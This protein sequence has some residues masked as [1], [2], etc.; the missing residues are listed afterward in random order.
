M[1]FYQVFMI[2]CVT[3]GTPMFLLMANVIYINMLNSCKTGLTG[4]CICLSCKLLL[5]LS[6]V[7]ACMHTHACTHTHA[8][9]HTTHTHS[10]MYGHT[11][12]Y[13]HTKFVDK[14][15]LCKPGIQLPVTSVPDNLIIESSN[16]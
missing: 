2:G 12:K 8:H 6:E 1:S 13:P 14:S 7:D 4:H 5:M 11:R 9:T 16:T 15:K 3:K 10:H